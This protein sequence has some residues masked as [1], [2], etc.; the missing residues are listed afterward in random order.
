ME[1]YPGR[2][3]RR[4]RE[5]QVRTARRGSG[6][7]FHSSGQR[8]DVSVVG[9]AVKVAQPID[10]YRLPVSLVRENHPRRWGC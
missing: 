10:C 4:T 7:A 2:V 9:A 8:D 5:R 6:A 3:E 1:W